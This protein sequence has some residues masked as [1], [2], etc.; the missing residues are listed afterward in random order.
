MSDAIAV[1]LDTNDAEWTT[2]RQYI[3][4]LREKFRTDDR[5]RVV[6]ELSEGDL[7]HLNYLNP[8]GR[9]IHGKESIGTHVSDLVTSILS[10]DTPIVLT[11]HGVEEFS[12]VED[13]MYLDTYTPIQ[14]GVDA[15]KRSIERTF[16]TAVDAIIAIST[17]DK[18]CLEN[19]GV[20]SGKL[21]HVPHG[22][23]EDFRPSADGET[24]SFVLH[25]SKCSPHKNPETIIETAKRID[26]KLVIAGGGW[27]EQYGNELAAIETVDLRGYVPQKELIDLYTGALAFYFPSTYEP[28][29]LPLLES[30]ACGTPVVASKYS[31]GLDICKESIA[32]VDPHDVDSHVAELRRLINDDDLRSKRAIIAEERAKEFTWNRTANATISVYETVL[33]R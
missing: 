11:E 10:S 21:H 25:V 32:L 17:M 27:E 15:A 6:D 31:A 26:T 22:V 8:I 20:T 19:G 24:G 12:L 23:G 18:R 30:L 33:G 13:T 14:K 29:G 1:Y 2:Q 9:L 5:I 4:H 28:F 7:A 3:D 16:S